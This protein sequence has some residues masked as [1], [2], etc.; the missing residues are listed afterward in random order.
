VSRKPVRRRIQYFGQQQAT[1]FLK[2]KRFGFWPDHDAQ[3][4]R[5]AAPRRG[6]GFIPIQKNPKFSI[7]RNVT[8]F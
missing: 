5:Q 3:G 7:K 4:G 2:A 6:A 8:V 1:S